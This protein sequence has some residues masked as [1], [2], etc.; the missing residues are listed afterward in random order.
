MQHDARERKRWNLR[1]TVTFIFRV[2]PAIICLPLLFLFCIAGAVAQTGQ[3]AIG[4]SV[5]DSAGALVQK[6][7]VEVVSDATGVK[8]STTTNDVG[9]FQVQALNPGMYTIMVAKSGFE[10]TTTKSV[11]VAGVG[12]TTIDVT[13]SVG[14]ANEVVTVNAGSDLLT[15]TQSDVTTT[16][17]H[18]IVES[19]PYPERSSLG[20]A[21]LVPGVQG[22]ALQPGGISTE[23]PGAYTSYVTPGASIVIGGAPPGTSSIV[24]DGSDVT[25]ASLARTGVNLSGPEVQE[26]TVIV[27]GLSARYGRTGGGVIVQSSTYGTK[28]YHGS[29]TYRHTDPYFNAFP[30][31][32]TAPN[33]LHENYYGFYVGGPVWLPK[34]YPHRDKTFFFVGVEPARMKNSFGFRGTFQTPDELA[35]HLH[36]SLA[37]LNQS[38]LKSSGYAAALAAPRV[39]S[40]NY[41]S[42]VDA[43]GFPNGPYDTA[44]IRSI[45]NDDVSAQLGKNQFAQYVLSQFPTPS[46]PGPYVKFDNGQG[47]SQNDGTNATYK[48][49]VL[50]TDNRYSIRIDHHFSDAD[51]MFV[52]Y[53]VIPV[54]AARF[55]AV[56]PT[57]PLTIVPTDEA[58][59]HDIAL[60]YTHV[61]SPTVVNSFHYS[62]MRVNQQRLP[63]PITRTKDYA[64]AYGLTPASFGFG[65]PSLGNLNQNG[66]AYTMQMGLSNAAIQV[67]Q[68]FIAGDDIT[69]THGQHLFQM[70][71]D[72]R[73]L[74]SNQYDLGGA[75]G[76]RYNFLGAQTNNGST[77]GAPLGTFI[78][79][80]ISAFSNTPVQI[81]GYYRWRYY[82]GYF[83]DDW[84]ITPKLTLN[85]GMR[86]EFETPRMEKFNNQAY[87]A[88]NTPGNLNGVLPTNTALCF[89]GACG[90][91]KTL[92]PAN[93][94]GF[95]P[96]LGFSYAPT[97]RMTVRA[98]YTLQRLPLTGYENL[99]DPNFNVAS[100]SVGNQS[101]GIVANSTV[102]YIT[103]PVGALTSS[104]TSLAGNRGPI[105]YSNGLAPVFV[106]QKSSVPYTQTWSM[107]LQYQPAAQTVL[108]ATY[109]GSKGTHLI[110][111]F[112]NP[113][114]TALNVP[115]LNT[116]VN[117]V[118][119]H[120][121]LG[122]SSPN[123]YGITQNGAL[124]SES[125]LQL[126][127]PYQNFFN[128]TIPEIYPRG[129]TMEYNG[130]YLSVNQRFGH[131]LSL[132]A[133]YT[134]SKTLDNVPDT[135]TGANGGGFGAALPQNPY[136]ANAEWAVASFDQASRLKA[137]YTYDLPIGQGYFLSS[138][139]R[140][141]DK[142]IGNISTAGIATFA[143]GL[144][145]AVTL[146]T[147]G[148]FVSVTPGGT[149]G[150]TVSGTNKYCTANAL[151]GGYTLRPD[152]VPGVPLINKNWKKN[153]LN[154]NFTPYLNPAAFAVPG[155]I[156]NPRLGN[157]PRTLAGAR[158]P[159]QALFDMRFVKGFQFSERYK[160]NVN[161]TFSNVFNHPVYYGVSR[162]LNSSNTVSNVTG[163]ITPVGTANF[164]QFNQSQTAGM[165]RVIRIGAEFVF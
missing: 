107:T 91:P 48:R 65:F 41:Q 43:N 102:N 141:V 123:K 67:D 71:A 93:Y 54:N 70:G 74:Q 121:N 136:D 103:N 2:S 144:P 90:N 24:V 84:R 81:P 157:A 124:V 86:Y 87:I 97:A 46:N 138:H 96:R 23:N 29:V 158:S 21:L 156:N 36:N 26:A 7:T 62:F 162:A 105:L 11:N 73:W 147:V 153:A 155:S 127:N 31:G 118:Q 32:N 114:S 79:G 28:D 8:L 133:N 161:A 148:Y 130:L 154:S 150:C 80:T 49:G 39:G 18:A 1:H 78:L 137:G 72:I 146:G 139:N 104:Y 111:A 37:L 9:V 126:L 134:W 53:T 113:F 35:G 33:A 34:I 6:A 163:T 120:Q 165:S 75:T 132:L 44:Q 27:T 15:K 20:A 145:S 19:L 16:V 68:N 109:N 10:K 129:G 164:G 58:N 125:N 47:T 57:N 143:D 64:A 115:T 61:F 98:A 17:D 108:Q 66:V 135:N 76:G 69:W 149:N 117:A 92:W 94:K 100:Q 42:T 131:G 151:P 40:I 82:A 13:L 116:I 52:R 101:G 4:G 83:Q 3:G 95:E 25:Q 51:Q 5:K 122:A 55:F 14:T 56:D 112:P 88:L 45:A 85:L 160:L 110:G 38:V 128:Q 22:D 99:P 63:P 30:D 12:V 77:G 159:R 59:T 50:N 140:F 106:S 142:L 152:I 89:S 119:T 60:G